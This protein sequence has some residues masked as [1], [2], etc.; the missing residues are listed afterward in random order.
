M[1]YFYTRMTLLARPR[2]FT[3]TILSSKHPDAFPSSVPSEAYARASVKSLLFLLRYHMRP[4][5]GGPPHLTDLTPGVCASKRKSLRKAITVTP[6]APS[7]R[8]TRANLTKEEVPFNYL[9]KSFLNLIRYG[10]FFFLT[11]PRKGKGRGVS[12]L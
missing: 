2:I 9:G 1:Q 3:P 11:C 12:N 4:P 6:P 8:A 10:F 7:G 5:A